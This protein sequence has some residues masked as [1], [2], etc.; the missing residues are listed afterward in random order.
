MANF[1][2]FSSMDRWSYTDLWSL[3]VTAVSSPKISATSISGV[4]DGV[5]V[6]MG[7]RYS[8][9]AYGLTGGTVSSMSF[10]YGGAMMASVSGLALDVVDLAYSSPERVESLMFSGSDTVFSDWS[11]GAPYL[12]Y[13]GDDRI[14]LGSGDDILDSGSGTDTFVLAAPFQPGAISLSGST[15]VINSVK[16]RD[17]LSNVEIVEFL[18]TKIALLV[19]NAYNDSLNGD[20]Q[21]GILM[22]FLYGNGGNDRIAG[23]TGN[24][25]L[26]GNSGDDDLFGEKGVDTLLGGTGRDTLDGGA[27]ADRLFGQRGNDLLQGSTGNDLLNGG[28]GRDILIGQKGD[29]VLTGGAGRDIFVFRKRH[30]DNRITDFQIGLDTIEIGLGASDLSD[31]DFA[32]KG[33][34]V[35]V[36][37]ADVSILVEDV[38]RADLRDIGNFDL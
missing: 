32:R 29:D 21:P 2:I 8:F 37:F 7:G 6:T 5:L 35:L 27:H 23:G 11:G 16:G 18:D 12:T 22:D 38:T 25:R 20:G 10:S 28:G 1:R 13:G 19:G 36:T 3:D 26:F 24:D 15:V 17:T 31:L 34:D 14:T 4:V 33:A 9:D 30:G